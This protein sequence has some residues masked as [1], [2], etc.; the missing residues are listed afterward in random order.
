MKSAVKTLVT[1]E[2][3]SAIIDFRFWVV[4]ALCVSIIPLS[5]Y[6]S[7]KNY[8]QR[9]SDFVLF[10][11][12]T[13]PSQ[14][15][16][17]RIQQGAQQA[18]GEIQQLRQMGRHDEAQKMQTHLQRL[19]QG[20]FG[21]GLT[22]EELA[23]R[24]QYAV[25][26]KA[27]RSIEMLKNSPHRPFPICKENDGVQLGQIEVELTPEE[28]EDFGIKILIQKVVE[29]FGRIFGEKSVELIEV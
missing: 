24:G 21:I 19:Q 4:L 7:V 26:Y 10:R 14:G 12:S 17:Q 18:Q 15:M 20:N 22:V 11:I 25:E 3:Q 9:L 8:S 1:R 5:F 13:Q 27:Y 2:I 23:G 28:Q 16:Q 29:L 6:V